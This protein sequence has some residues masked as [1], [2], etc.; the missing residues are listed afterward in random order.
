[1][2]VDAM[3]SIMGEMMTDFNQY[4]ELDEIMEQHAKCKFFPIP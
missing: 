3:R 1:V 2:S 4:E